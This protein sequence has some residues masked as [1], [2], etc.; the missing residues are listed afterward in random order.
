[1]ANFFS[2]QDGF[3]WF[4]GVV[5]DRDDPEKLG[6]VR[7][8]CVGY[9]SNDLEEIP[10]KDLPW[11]WVLSTVHTSM[12][13]LGHTPPFLVEGT[14][15]VGFWRDPPFYQEAIIFGTLPGVPAEDVR[16]GYLTGVPPEHSI[17]DSRYHGSKTSSPPIS[18][19]CWRFG[20]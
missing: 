15:V 11:S 7:V 13:G 5:E 16:Y 18:P 1:M 2:G 14:W 6:R 19:S 9:H 12:N 20:P 3:V 4:T 10:T 17:T 8:R